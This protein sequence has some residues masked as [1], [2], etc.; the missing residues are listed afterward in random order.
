VTAYR[1]WLT[2]KERAAL[3][4]DIGQRRVSC[5]QLMRMLEQRL[6]EENPE[7]ASSRE[8]LSDWSDSEP[9]TVEFAG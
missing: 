1:L 4:E 6:L 3:A 9:A 8:R 2:E 5:R 7:L